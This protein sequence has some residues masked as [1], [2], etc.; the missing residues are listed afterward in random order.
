M[1][2]NEEMEMQ[3]WA[4]I[5]DSCNPMDKTRI[6]MLVQQN[7]EWREKY[8]E[9]VELHA[10]ITQNM[11]LD[12]PSLRFSRN[13]MDAVG[14]TKMVRST[15]QYIN[16]SIIRGIAAFFIGV[17]SVCIIYAFATINWNAAPGEV[18][19]GV[20]L[21]NLKLDHILNP[22]VLNIIIAINI[23]LA[24]ALADKILRKR[25]HISQGQN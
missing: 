23:I 20:N 1:E 7:A 14:A 16:K 18:L 13:V 2:Q 15:K 9:L 10:G 11:E 19:K 22:G 3:I 25:V 4:F 6:A 5:D 17:I 24:L 8:E 21:D 12:E